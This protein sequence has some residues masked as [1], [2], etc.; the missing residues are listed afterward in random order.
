MTKE[1][2]IQQV[3]AHKEKMYRVSF[4]ILQNDQD[5]Q[6]ALQEAALKAWEKQHTLRNDQYFATW[7]TRIVINE[8]YQIRRRQKRLIYMEQLPDTPATPEGV[9]LRLLLE[10]LPEKLR[11][12]F[13]MKYSEGMR[14]EDIAYALHI[15]RSAVNGR[16][17]RAKALMR[18]ELNMDDGCF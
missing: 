8:S 3:A 2:Y 13:M 10:T 12:P 5:V 4:T 18:K 16:I 17:N 14:A 7:M 6:D 1:S 15:T 11:L 9:T